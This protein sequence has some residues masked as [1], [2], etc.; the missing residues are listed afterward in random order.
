M[1]A[2]TSSVSPPASSSIPPSTV[3]AWDFLQTWINSYETPLPQALLDKCKP[4]HCE[5]CSAQLNSSQQ[6]Q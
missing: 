4:L 1:E 5:L 3:I 6:A 2:A